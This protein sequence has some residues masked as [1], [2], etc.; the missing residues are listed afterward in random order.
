MVPFSDSVSEYR[1]YGSTE[2]H[3]TRSYQV[4]AMIRSSNHWM[5]AYNGRVNYIVAYQGFKLLSTNKEGKDAS[6]T[7]CHEE[8]QSSE[9]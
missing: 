4:D 7:H 2:G 5:V 6:M 3:V 8:Y 9:T 1:E